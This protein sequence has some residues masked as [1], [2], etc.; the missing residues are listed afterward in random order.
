MTSAREFLPLAERAGETGCFPQLLPE[1]GGNHHLGA[2]CTPGA[3]PSQQLSGW[4]PARFAPCCPV[5]LQ[6]LQG[7]AGRA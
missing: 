6:S 4:V 7:R 1:P 5:E 3:C 2:I